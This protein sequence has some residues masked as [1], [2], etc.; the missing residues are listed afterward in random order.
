M[1]AYTSAK[2]GKPLIVA[3]AIAS[4]TF[5]P[6]Q[7]QTARSQSQASEQYGAATS[8]DNLRSIVTALNE[9]RGEAFRRRD[10]S[11]VAQNF[12]PDAVYVELM[13]RLEVLRGREEI[14]RHYDELV[15]AESS[16][17]TY[18]VTSAE[19]TGNNTIAV[20]GDYVLIAG[21]NK[22]IQG[23]YFQELRSDGGVWKIA[24]N[25]FARPEPVTVGE[26][27]AYRGN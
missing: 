19:A 1:S 7:A 25:V 8:E 6:A 10:T 13:P 12:T 2:Q 5:L 16:N 18:T 9:R 3:L 15:A 11:A 26:V 21:R 14:K 27:D 24:M 22:R 20:G 17:L 4:L 23:H